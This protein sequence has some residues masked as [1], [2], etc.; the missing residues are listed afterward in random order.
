MVQI[1]TVD[2]WVFEQSRANT[3][4]CTVMYSNYIYFLFLFNAQEITHIITYI[5]DPISDINDLLCRILCSRFE[6]LD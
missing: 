5:P 4:L 2:S 6:C 1:F 3:L